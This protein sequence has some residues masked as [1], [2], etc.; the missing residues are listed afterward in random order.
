MKTIKSI[1]AVLTLVVFVIIGVSCNNVDDDILTENPSDITFAFYYTD[2]DGNNMLNDE[3]CLNN[4]SVVGNDH[5][6]RLW[7]ENDV[8]LSSNRTNLV[9]KESNNGNV[10]LTL[11]IFDGKGNYDI[12]FT[13]NWGDGTIDVV[14]LVNIAEKKSGGYKL[15]REYYLNDVQIEAPIIHHIKN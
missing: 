6:Y 11:G 10:T 15:I 1:I 2:K 9:Y 13:I 3:E 5:V 8:M 12:D 14:R 4:I 7:S